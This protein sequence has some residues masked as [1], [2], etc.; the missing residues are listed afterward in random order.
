MQNF[1]PKPRSVPRFCR[2]GVGVGRLWTLA[3]VI[4]VEDGRVD[5]LDFGT[6]WL[7]MAGFGM[8]NVFG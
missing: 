3:L 2:C 7:V 5:E 4:A 1:N 8:T 6:M